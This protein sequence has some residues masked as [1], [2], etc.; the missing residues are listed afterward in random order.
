MTVGQIVFLVFAALAIAG[1]LMV[2]ISRRL[3]HA[4]LWLIL[5]LIA[6]AALYVLLQAEFLAAVQVAIYVGAIAILII[7]GV[8]LTRRSMQEG[9][10]QVN[11]FW[12]V[13]GLAALL[14]FGGLVLI[15]RRIP[16]FM[17]IPPELSISGGETIEELG[18]SL[19]DIDRY[20]LPFEV[21]SVLLLAA[22][23]GSIVVA[24]PPTEDEQGGGG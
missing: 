9:T 6:V 11:R 17:A 2:V 4:A 1:S 7:F 15:L 24:R 10:R 21:A 18:R 20:V 13:A 12:W 14:L 5:C 3:V 8:M 19:V 16:A 22:L 23:I